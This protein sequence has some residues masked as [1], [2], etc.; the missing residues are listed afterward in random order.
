M[1]ECDGS[2]FGMVGGRV[3]VEQFRLESQDDEGGVCEQA[4]KCRVVKMTIY[5]VHLGEE[6]VGNPL[7]GLNYK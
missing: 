4:E 6:Y 3:H 7:S 2:W 1:V 5:E